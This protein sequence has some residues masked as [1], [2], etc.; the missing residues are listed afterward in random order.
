MAEDITPVRNGGPIIGD[1][2]GAGQLINSDLA[3]QAYNDALSPTM[4]EIGGLS[5]DFLK[6]IRLFAAPIQLLASYQDRF[7]AFCDRVRAKVPEEEQCKAPPE[8]ARPVMEAF[9]STSDDSP[10]MSMFEELM[11]KAI[12]KRET[13]KLSPE[14]APLIKR[15]SPLE[16][17]LVADLYKQDQITD[18]L[19]DPKQRLIVQRINANFDFGRFCGQEHHLTLIQDLKDKNLVALI[20]HLPVDVE[21]QYPGLTIP[22]GLELKRTIIRLSMFGRWFATACVAK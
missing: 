22:Q 10:L 16:A 7:R 2:V 1:L 12:D 9:A 8:I 3:K 15:L 6:T 21:K 11:A 13:Q 14:F 5:Q 19:L 20:E 18:D 4:K 17:M